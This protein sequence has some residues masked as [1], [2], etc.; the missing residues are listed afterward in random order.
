MRVGH[1]Y[2][3]HRLAEG[4]K[5]ILGGVCIPLGKGP[6]GP[7]RRRCSDSCGDGCPGG[8]TTLKHV[9]YGNPCTCQPV[10]AEYDFISDSGD[11]AAAIFNRGLC[12]PS[13]IKNT[14]EDM[15]KNYRH[16]E[17]VFRKI[18]GKNICTGKFVKRF[19]LIFSS[20]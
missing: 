17:K 20:P 19:S 5:L 1:G 16:C 14:E 15:D 8:V 11:A 4:R 2:D 13:D 9:L 18:R 6:F 12:L 3:V 10:F 7:L